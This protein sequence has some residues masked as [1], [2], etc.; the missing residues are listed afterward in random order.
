MFNRISTKM[1]LAV[2]LLAILATGSLGTIS[3]YFA[4]EELVRS[5]ELDL[6]HIVNTSIATLEELNNQVENGTLTLDEAQEKAR[7]ILVGPAVVKDGAKTY[8]YTK[9]AFVY[10]SDGYLMAYDSQYN[11]RL[12]PI[13]P[14]GENKKDV[15]NSKGQHVVKNIVKLA[16]AKDPSDRY[17]SYSWKNTGEKNER[18]K[19]VYLS[20][21]A[22]WDWNIG[23]GAYEEEFYA[24]LDKLK[25]IVGITSLVITALGA[26]FFYL[27]ARSKF[28][29]LKQVTQASLDISEGILKERDLPESA[30]EIGQLSKGFNKMTHQLRSIITNIQ[31]MSE[32]VSN[33]SLELSALSE[34][35]SAT[36]EEVSKAI[37][38]I[39]RGTVA[40]ASDIE[41]TSQRT[42]ALVA[43]INQI[44][45][46]NKKMIMLTEESSSS[47]AVG[48][49]KVVFLQESNQESMN[50]G[51]KVSIGITQ[52]YNRI[53]DISTIL[54][55]ID[56]ISKQTNLLALNA[57]IEAARAG[58]YGK[59]FAVVAEEVR[60]LAEQTNGATAEINSM[61][62]KIE[63]DTE[64]IVMTMAGSADISKNL[65]QAVSETEGQFNLI[66]DSMHQILAAIN[67]MGEEVTL[68]TEN[69]NDIMGAIQNITA[70]AEETAASSEEIMASVDEQV[71]VIST[72]AA[73]AEN[74]TLLSEKLNQISE[75]FTIE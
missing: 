70:V 56:S 72:I 25:W 36:S 57:S 32:K 28:N 18:D 41:T 7:E 49:E 27:G 47:I 11:A 35:T 71:G 23:M 8:D 4:K 2:T 39:T 53:R 75:Q 20:Y 63:M 19:I 30:D 12:H 59:G 9:S 58:E 42:D 37:N 61:I 21:Y 1:I 69:G 5:G 22:P 48:K 66:S 67:K 29:I 31:E 17:Y 62:E 10:K 60:K 43:A 6:Q 46:Q 52:L 24:S 55:T 3:Y 65:N 26:F 64:N 34:E 40:Q 16:K 50:S 13:I 74:L 68:V 14:I 15:V 45:E 51:E 33:S 44:N 38:E 73:S 54:T